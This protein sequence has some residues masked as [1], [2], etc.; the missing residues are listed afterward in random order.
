LNANYYTKTSIDTSLNANYYTKTSIDT[1]LNANYYNKTYVDSSLNLLKPIVGT[2]AIQAAGSTTPGF[3]FTQINTTITSGFS[4]SGSNA[5]QSGALSVTG[6]GVFILNWKISMNPT[7]SIATTVIIAGITLATANTNNENNCIIGSCWKDDETRTLSSG[8]YIR[9]G[10]CIVKQSD[11]QNYYGL[12][13]I[14]YSTNSPSSV[15][16]QLEAVRIA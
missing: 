9:S 14:N 15:N 16:F 2:V 5:L 3:F 6:N 8:N 1:S 4:T 7:S 11:T 12:F 10:S 13:K